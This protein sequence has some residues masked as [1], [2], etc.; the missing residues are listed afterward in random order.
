MNRS[1]RWLKRLFWIVGG[2]F[3]LVG[4]PAWYDRVVNQLQ[5]VNF[6][7]IVP[8]GL[9]EAGYIYFVG[10]SAGAFLI[11][12]LVYVFGVKRFERIGRVAVF[13]AL[14]TLLMALLMVWVG[15]GH[16][17]RVWHVL[18]YPNFR[19]LM[20]AIIWLYG[21]YFLLLL[22]ELWFLLRSDLVAG[23]AEHDLKAKVYRILSLGARDLSLESATRDRRVV[24]GLATI[25][26]PLAVMFHGGVGS[27]FG[28]V[29]A[30]PL[31]NSGLF[32]VLFLI[33][34]LVSGGALLTVIA[35]IFQDGWT[36]NRDIVLALGTLV[37]GLM[38][39]DT[40]FQVSEWLIALYGQVPEHIASLNL[41][42]RGPYWWVFWGV[43]LALGTVLPLLLLVMP[44]RHDPRWVTLAALLITIGFAALRL[45][46]VVP[47]LAIEEIQ[48]LSQ[49][50]ASPRLTTNYVPSLMEWSIAVG[51]VGFGL[52]LFGLGEWLLP[53]DEKKVG[54]VPA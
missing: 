20:A 32:P 13:T 11:S 46:I 45:N 6:G 21:A 2:L 30:R 43:Q 48:G 14:V 5:H 53:K 26:V 19:S 7:S 18:V 28:V 23:A 4:I 3:F 50:L 34:A 16:F 1:E 8:W 22:A 12:S 17:E 44:T 29:V 36:R 52:L 39:L 33:S 31:W 41:I 40:L 25:G 37:L 35:A 54:H 49:A 27:L 15:L 10:L 51:I 24:R 42:V 47:G 9:W 38:L